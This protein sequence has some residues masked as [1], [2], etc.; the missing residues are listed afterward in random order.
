MRSIVVLEDKRARLGSQDA[1]AACHISQFC[2]GPETTHVVG[3]GN[4]DV[5]CYPSLTAGEQEPT[6]MT[7]CSIPM[8]YLLSSISIPII[9]E[10]AVSHTLM[11]CLDAQA[12]SH[13]HAC[14]S[15]Q[16]LYESS[17]RSEVF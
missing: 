6:V 15:P 14:W 8:T 9:L 10:S 17:G 4:G 11:S 5:R 7:S 16:K 3:L 12:M 13:H 2:E 1:F